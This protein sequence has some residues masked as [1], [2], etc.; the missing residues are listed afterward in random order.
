MTT[1]DIKAMQPGDQLYDD[2]VKGLICRANQTNKSFLLVY[3]FHGRQRKPK[4]GNWP[5]ITLDQAR[6]VAKEMLLQL[7]SGN[8][9]MAVRD[10]KRSADTIKQAWKRYLTEYAHGKKTGKEDI[11]IYK[12]HIPDWFKRLPVSEVGYGEIVRIRDGLKET[13]YQAN[14]TIALISKFL[15]LMEVWGL[16]SMGSNPC[17]LVSRFREVP[18]RRYMTRDELAAISNALKKREK[19][20]PYSVAFIRLLM[21][22]G[23]RS[24]ELASAKWADLDGQ[25]IVLQEHKTDKDGHP[26]VIQLPKAAMEVI[27]SLPERLPSDTILTIKSPKRLWDLVRQEAGCPDLRMH[28]LRHSFASLALGAGYTLY[29]IGELLGHKSE[30][31][32]KRYAHLMD[33]AASAAAEEVASTIAGKL[34]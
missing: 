11:R 34:L 33:E 29:Q 30:G 24:G 1:T 21:L 31:T 3:R 4:V 8:D 18:R 27:A 9:P 14:R 23:A 17:H 5:T 28:D 22:T 19:Q 7:A 32:T 6:R 20:E 25:R 2:Q 16:R 13:P 10:A 12:V 26:R 15:C